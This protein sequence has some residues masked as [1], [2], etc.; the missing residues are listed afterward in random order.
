MKLIRL[1]YEPEADILYITFGQPTAAT[2]YQ[3]SDQI[4]L[5]VDPETQRVAG[6]TILNFSVHTEADREIPL[7]GLEEDPEVKP[8]LLHLLSASPVAHFLRV[9][10]GDQGVSAMLLRPSLQEVLVG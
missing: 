2:G 5:R 10:E 9:V 4:L 6:L 3:L 1:T 8:F 7:S